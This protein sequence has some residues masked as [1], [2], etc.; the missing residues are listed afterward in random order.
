LDINTNTSFSCKAK[1]KAKT[2]KPWLK[3]EKGK[4]TLKLNC[5]SIIM[6]G[7]ELKSVVKPR[8][9]TVNSLSTFFPTADK[10]NIPTS[11]SPSRLRKTI[12]VN[13]VSW[14]TPPPGK[15]RYPKR[16]RPGKNL[17]STAIFASND[18][19]EYTAD[20]I[21]VMELL[22]QDWHKSLH[23]DIKY[24]R[25]FSVYGQVKLQEA[26]NSVSFL[27]GE[28]NNT[29]TCTSWEL[30][31]QLFSTIPEPA[32][33]A[34]LS[35]LAHL[36]HPLFSNI[37]HI[38][39]YITDVA[40]NVA[41]NKNISD[42]TSSFTP[43]TSSTSSSFDA[44]A[45]TY[46]ELHSRL[47]NKINRLT[48]ISESL[49]GQ[50]QAS[51]KESA[52]RQ[53]QFNG[54][55][56][57]WQKSYK[58]MVLIAWHK[59]IKHQK[60]CSRK[61][62][63]VLFSEQKGTNTANKVFA[64]RLTFY[65]WRSAVCIESS[66]RL[67]PMHEVWEKKAIMLQQ[68]MQKELQKSQKMK[69]IVKDLTK[70]LQKSKNFVQNKRNKLDLLSNKLNR[71]NKKMCPIKVILETF[72]TTALKTF[73]CY[74]DSLLE[75]MK[76]GKITKT[77]PKIWAQKNL[78]L[79]LGKDS[80]NGRERSLFSRDK[81]TYIPAMFKDDEKKKQ[82]KEKHKR[83]S[84]VT[85]FIISKWNRETISSQLQNSITYEEPSSAKG[86]LQFF[87][88]RV[89]AFNH[90][91]P[92]VQ[93]SKKMNRCEYLS[94]AALM[95]YFIK[96]QNQ[97]SSLT[98]EMYSVLEKETNNERKEIEH[99]IK[100]SEELDKNIIPGKY[101]SDIS[102]LTRSQLASQTV[103]NW[104]KAS[105][106]FFLE[107]GILG[108]ALTSGKVNGTLKFGTHVQGWHML[109]RHCHIIKER[110]KKRDSI[111]N[112]KEKRKNNVLNLAVS[113]YGKFHRERLRKVIESDMQSKTEDSSKTLANELSTELDALE[114]LT[115][116]FA[117]EIRGWY[118]RYSSV[119]GM[120]THDFYLFVKQIK[121]LSRSFRLVDIDLVRVASGAGDDDDMLS[122]PEFVEALIRLGIKRYAFAYI[123]PLNHDSDVDYVDEELKKPLPLTVATADTGQCKSKRAVDRV[124]R[125]LLENVQEYA[126]V[127][128][129]DSFRTRFADPDVQ[130]ILVKRRRWLLGK[131]R[132]YAAA[133]GSQSSNNSV[134]S[135]NLVEWNQFLK[136]HEMFDQRFKNRM[137]ANIFVCAQAPQALDEAGS[138]EDALESNQELIYQE[139]L[140]AIVALAHFHFPDPFVPVSSRVS[141]ILDKMEE[142]KPLNRYFASTRFGGLSTVQA[143]TAT[144]ASFIP[145]E[146]Q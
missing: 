68:K 91:V 136:D 138:L 7:E 94:A 23:Q 59:Y 18:V 92:V 31:T 56:S 41:Y 16:Q 79:G 118:I 50:R 39:R 146:K 34:L 74:S 33:P 121:V 101:A 82:R 52:K 142:A 3:Q 51:A 8:T 15:K 128:D 72:A 53:L 93:R 54:T 100:R 4:N 97:P 43:V 135:M 105:E 143:A 75:L 115:S 141:K 90:L 46:Q 20:G 63:N 35:V 28:T 125:L 73:N 70:D 86:L 64:Q 65:G 30:L 38:L 145:E 109:S 67:G 17:Q 47:K 62:I 111:R 140:E 29:V 2:L 57:I 36:A 55:I 66:K 25:S 104:K 110:R 77:A 123:K 134:G 99:A 10:N 80:K 119:K 114:A 48:I 83:P 139:F 127:V 129:I 12:S 44:G 13:L 32:G 120:G 87:G 71:L 22:L 69:K 5:N 106:N 42:F 96:D 116:E 19:Q 26:R 122:P 126:H 132:E 85:D 124:R 95:H 24:F 113:M 107:G 133:D 89:E 102:G 108:R 144:L 130:N 1:T 37:N 61:L 27:Q 88:T 14:P 58:K 60:H 103:L 112:Q 40:S 76:Y 81:S 9:N 117:P 45:V 6:S 21:D 137:S 11:K 78:S 49:N 98:D 131:F 84:P